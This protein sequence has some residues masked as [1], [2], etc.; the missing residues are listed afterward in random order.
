MMLILVS[1]VDHPEMD[2]WV[3]EQAQE[4][5]DRGG[6]VLGDYLGREGAL[7]LAATSDMCCHAFRASRP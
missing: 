1:A 5:A 2:D 7:D 3:R 6:L 4:E